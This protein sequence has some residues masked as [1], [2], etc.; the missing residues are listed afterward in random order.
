VVVMRS[1]NFGELRTYELRRIHLLRRS[2]NKGQEGQN[3]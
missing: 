3:P 2:V 1:E